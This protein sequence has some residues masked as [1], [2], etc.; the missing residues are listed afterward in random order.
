[1]SRSAQGLCRGLGTALICLNRFLYAS[2]WAIFP[3]FLCFVA[4]LYFSFELIHNFAERKKCR[5][6]FVLAS[7]CRAKPVFSEVFKFDA[8]C[9]ADITQ[10][11]REEKQ[12]SYLSC[13]RVQ[14]SSS[15]LTSQMT[16][17]TKMKII[18][19]NSSYCY[20]SKIPAV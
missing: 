11:R 10:T 8:V 17:F 2:L 15:T 5:I 20:A 9:F 16:N 13:V 7:S 1:M 18:F 6:Q 19:L 14:R 12:C 3:P 4:K